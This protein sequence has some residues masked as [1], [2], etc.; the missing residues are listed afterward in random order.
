MKIES[1]IIDSGS[2]TSKA[3]FSD[4]EGPRVEM[5]TVLGYP[6]EQEGLG[7]DTDQID[8]FVGEEAIS[9]GGVLKQFWPVENTVINDLNTI[10]KIWK[11][12]FYNELLAETKSNPVVISH[13]P[14]CSTQ[15]KRKMIEVLFENMNVEVLY[16]TNTA[17][18]AL[19]ANGRTTGLVADLGY[20]MSTFVPI[21]EGYVIDHT[22]TTLELGGYHLTEY[23]CNLINSNPENDIKYLNPA[24]KSM[25]NELKERKAHVAEDYDSEMKKLIDSGVKTV[26]TMPDGSKVRLMGETMQTPELLFQPSFYNVENTGIHE[27]T[28]KAIKACDEDIHKDL[29]FNV[30]LC[31]GTSMFK[32]IQPRFQKE[33]QSL[34]PTGKVVNV[35]APPERKHS[36]WL[37]G[38]ILSSLDTFR[39]NLFITK[40]EYLDKGEDAIFNKFF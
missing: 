16:L 28:F 32:K 35:I 8:V 39:E 34:A 2:Y 17:N 40:K 29:F 37:G 4:D 1:I 38:A 10:E 30:V 31:G 23:L 9:K 22:I 21:Y 19:Y 26:Y 24:E 15:T 11:H 20:Q 33:V 36:A 25:I 18:L 7:G 27:Q 12:I 13:S 5:P 3:G 14:L 6:S